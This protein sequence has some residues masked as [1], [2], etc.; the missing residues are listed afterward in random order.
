MLAVAGAVVLVLALLY[1]RSAAVA[2]G[3]D[4]TI[5]VLREAPEPVTPAPLEPMDPV[6]IN[7][8]GREELEELPGIGP[9]L[10]GRIIEY[11]EANGPFRSVEGLLE[12][13][14]IGEATLERLR[15]YVVAGTDGRQE[16]VG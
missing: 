12:V 2:P 10:A 15:E 9:A 14:G 3:T 7:T 5:S 16:D 6:D 13:S 4:Y 1:L 11:R 8:A